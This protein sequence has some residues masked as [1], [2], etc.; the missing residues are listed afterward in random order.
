M[1]IGSFFYVKNRATLFE[2]PL[3]IITP[4]SMLVNENVGSIFHKGTFAASASSSSA[5]S[6]STWQIFDYG[7]PEREREIELRADTMGD[8]G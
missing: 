6:I 3:C 5:Y 8:D 1:G 4:I 2:R 7:R